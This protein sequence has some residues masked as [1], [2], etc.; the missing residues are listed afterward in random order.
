MPKLG[1]LDRQELDENLA[2]IAGAVWEGVQ[3]YNGCN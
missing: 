2:V 3:E 1:S